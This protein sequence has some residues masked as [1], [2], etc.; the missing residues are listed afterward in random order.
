MHDLDP[1]LIAE[2][3]LIPIGSAHNLS[4]EFYGNSL[5]GKFE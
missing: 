2:D 3:S 4:I 1:V 5:N